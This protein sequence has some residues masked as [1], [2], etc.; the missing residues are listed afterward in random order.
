MVR[1]FLFSVVCPRSLILTSHW[2]RMNQNS[3]GE[4]LQVAPFNANS[5]PSPLQ[6][7]HSETCWICWP[8]IWLLKL[9]GPS[10]IYG[11][12]I[13]HFKVWESI[14]FP[15]VLLLVT[16]QIFEVKSIFRYISSRLGSCLQHYKSKILQQASFLNFHEFLQHLAQV[17]QRCSYCTA[18]VICNISREAWFAQP[19]F[20][21]LFT[22]HDLL[23]IFI[24]LAIII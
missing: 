17:A 6:E 22:T 8:A 20:I 9:R 15:G 21:A 11:R 3:A 18:F 4:L 7:G 12:C 13:W 10:M 23:Y 24:S 1:V 5:N 19:P 2:D 14:L 16:E